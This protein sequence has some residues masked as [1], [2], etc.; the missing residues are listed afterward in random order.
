VSYKIIR[1]VF[2]DLLQIAQLKFLMLTKPDRKEGQ[3]DEGR[4]ERVGQEL[5]RMGEVMG[6]K[7]GVGKGGRGGA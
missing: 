6:A 4:E 2:G 5:S 1:C 7:R 3:Q